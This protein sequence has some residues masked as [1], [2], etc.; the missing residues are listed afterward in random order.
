M[1]DP[2]PVRVAFEHARQLDPR[3]DPTPALHL[4]QLTAAWADRNR[5]LLTEESWAIACPALARR[6]PARMAA[7]DAADAWARRWAAEY[8]AATAAAS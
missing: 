4:L 2:S 6:S 1:T 3:P 7:A 5:R 8:S